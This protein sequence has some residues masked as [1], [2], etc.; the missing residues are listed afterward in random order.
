[1]QSFAFGKYDFD[2]IFK[3]IK[4]NCEGNCLE[5]HGEHFGEVERVMIKGFLSS[6]LT[7]NYCQ[8]AIQEDKNRGF[9]VVTIDEIEQ[10]R[11]IQESFYRPLDKEEIEYANA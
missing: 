4:M 2:C 1:M 10:N 9:E 11:L 3:S 6:S 5:T 7:F 8:N